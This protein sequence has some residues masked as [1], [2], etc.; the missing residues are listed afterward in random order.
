MKL[1]IEW[2][3]EYTEVEVT[4]QEYS[5]ALT[6]SGSKVEGVENPAEGMC[7]IITGKIIKIDKHPDA[8]R[9]VVCSVDAGDK[10]LQI[11]TAATNVFEGAI[12][13]V[14]VIGAV[15]ADGTKIKKAKL[16]GVE[17]EGMFCSVAELGLTTAD[18]PGAI[19]DGI[20]ILTDDTPIGVDALKLLGVD[21]D[22]VEFEI[23]S[24]RPDCMSVIG[25]ARETAVTFG[26]EL[27]K[28]S[29]P[30]E[31][32]EG[33]T[34]KI[35][36]VEVK[37]PE[38]CP[39]YCAKLVKNVKIEPSPIWMRNRL[40]A[41]GVR[42]INNI[43][44]ITNY[45]MLEYGQPM[46]AFDLRDIE[47]NKII[48]RCAEDGEKFV[49][50]DDQE[51]VL[52]SSMLMICDGKKPVG[53]AGVMGGANSEIKEDTTDILFEG[54]NFNYGSIRKTARALGLRTESSQRF[55]KGIDP[56][57]AMDAVERACQLVEML[58][59]GEVVDGVIDVNNVAETPAPVKFDAN[60]IN[61]F[62]G[63]DLDKDYMVKLLESLEFKVEGD[64][65]TP[66]TFRE[67][68]KTP[69]DVAEEIAR[70]YGYDNIPST[71]VNAETMTG[72]KT[73]PQRCKS[74]IKDFLASI[75]CY[76]TV[77]YTF[78]APS[79]LDK[80]GA[81]SD[82]KLR[83]AVKIANPLGEDSGL[84]RTTMLPSMLE[85]LSLNYSH[86]AEKVALYEV[87]EIFVKTDDV[88]PD[89]PLKVTVGMYGDC[90]FYTIKG[91]YEALFDEMKITDVKYVKC[92][93]DPS[94][95][96]GRCAKVYIGGEYAGEI[97]EIHPD[98]VDAY[99]I[100]EKTYIGIIDFD[101]MVKNS[102]AEIKYKKLPKFP[103]VDRDLAVIADKSVQIG[104]LTETATKAAGKYLESITLFDIYEG[105]QIPE[106]K[107]SV[108]FSLKYR[109][110][111]K[112]LTDAEVSASFE[113]IL[114]ALE[115]EYGAVLR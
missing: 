69:A 107:K 1:P 98:V 42:S 76:E 46:H 115:E 75:G 26:K 44:D 81:A 95:H 54:A 106:G 39:R 27:R 50:L 85:A 99:G 56:A 41:C 113:K 32:S 102:G 6:M 72:Y 13:P 66:P 88:L 94:Y 48:V 10:T 92:S 30:T 37:N 104:D 40:H 91:V 21:T 59:A 52:N 89:E 103:A 87:G 86:R 49:T 53:V 84:M 57:L 51:R 112:T 7:G 34:G 82:S 108:A 47:D 36:S 8:D 105:A 43:V 60:W 61:G 29:L 3:K 80:I 31:S 79:A 2:L 101:I 83:D 20:L 18:Y 24:N 90:D 14:S 96:P 33:E 12:V 15:L 28:P 71:L 109:N 38:L 11:V 65:V 78:M 55:E 23:T 68:I 63:T 62:L 74:K 4:P 114:K 45:V 35:V 67:E 16:R 25:I 17:S 58:G 70:F 5:D 111:E 19:E 100:E 93:D 110:P 9:M 73:Y 22:I 64:K 77:T 97:G